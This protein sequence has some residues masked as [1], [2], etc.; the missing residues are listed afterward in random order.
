[1]SVASLTIAALSPFYITYNGRKTSGAANAAG[2]GIKLNTTTIREARTTDADAGV[3][4]TTANEA[5]NGGFWGFIGARATNYDG[6]GTGLIKTV[7]TSNGNNRVH[8]L[9]SGMVNTNP[10]PVAEITDFVIR[11]LTDSASQTLAV[12]ELHIYSLATS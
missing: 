1:M 4:F 3:R 2:C 5:Q 10:M 6:F 7:T 11:G 8:A 12:D 9:A